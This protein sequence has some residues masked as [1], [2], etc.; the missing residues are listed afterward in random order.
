MC[1]DGKE[2][3]QHQ[4]AYTAFDC[5]AEDL[6]WGSHT[7]TVEVDNRFGEDDAL[8]VPNDYYIYGGLNR[9]VTV[10][11]LG[12]A[13]IRSMRAVPKKQGR[14]WKVALQIEVVSLSDEDQVIDVETRVAGGERRW[15][16]KQLHAGKRWS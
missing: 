16:G 10:E 13:W 9:P 2:L 5:V 4:G 8:H 12:S 3:T 6:S 15:K 1:L 14:L 7:L 11:Q